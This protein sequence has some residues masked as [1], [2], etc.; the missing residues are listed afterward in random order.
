MKKL[1]YFFFIL[2]VCSFLACTNEKG[3]KRIE[4]RTQ[5]TIHS[6]TLINYDTIIINLDNR[7]S[8]NSVFKLETINKIEYLGT[9]NKDENFYSLYNLGTGN[10]ENRIIFSRT[11][12]NGIGQARYVNIHNMDSIFVIRHHSN[13]I[14]L[15]DSTAKIKNKWIITETKTGDFINNISANFGFE[16]LFSNNTLSFLNIPGA[17]AFSKK[18]WNSN[19]G[20]VFNIKSEEINN[21]TG[22]YPEVFK[23]GIC[24][25]NYNTSPYRVKTKLNQEVF[26]FPLDNRLYIYSDT[27]LIRIVNLHSPHIIEDAPEPHKTLSGYNFEDDWMYEIQK[28][29]YRWMVYDK[30]NDVIYRLI[31]HSMEPYDL[32]GNKNNVQDKSFSIQIIDNTFS[33]IGEV[34]FPSK[35]FEPGNII[36]TEN[37][38]LISLCHNDN[39][40]LEEDKLKLARFE[41]V[42]NDK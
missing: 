40:I 1:L 27:A 37:G 22:K 19:T 2:F 9:L 4:T 10:L 3:T 34:D 12:L 23:K 28:G 42:K 7:T 14:Y 17:K 35:T 30:Y 36:V 6:F 25:G 32:D 18:F 41:L 31:M 39:P 29:S 5:Q 26:S 24:Y 20:I 16:L 38:L 8:Y 21:L 33:L 13:K 15:T 11:G